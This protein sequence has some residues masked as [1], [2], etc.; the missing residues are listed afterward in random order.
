[1]NNVLPTDNLAAA[2]TAGSILLLART[3]GADAEAAV[4]AALVSARP[5]VMAQIGPT[6]PPDPGA[7][8]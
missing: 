7:I 5:D 4:R 2:R 1:M 3:L 8:Q 6:D